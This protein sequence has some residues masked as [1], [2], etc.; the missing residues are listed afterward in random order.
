MLIRW[1]TVMVMLF[2]LASMGCGRHCIRQQLPPDS[3]ADFSTT[4]NGLARPAGQEPVRQRALTNFPII[5]TPMSPQEMEQRIIAL[6]VARARI[7]K[8]I[9]GIQRI[10]QK[11]TS[12]PPSG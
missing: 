4:N 8:N 3:M 5:P 2:A 6:E 12:P 10:I 11:P 9:E 7:D 1:K